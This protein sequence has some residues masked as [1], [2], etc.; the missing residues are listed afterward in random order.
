VEKRSITGSGVPHATI[1]MS[2]FVSAYRRAAGDLGARDARRLAHQQKQLLRQRPRLP[3]RLAR[4]LPLAHFDD[5]FEDGLLGLL[6]EPLQPAHAAFARRLFQLVERR[7]VELLDERRRLPRPQPR[8]RHQ[9][10]RAV[11]K[12]APQVFEI[13]QGPVLNQLG[14]LLVDGFPHAGKLAECSRPNTF[15]QPARRSR[16]RRQRLERIRRQVVSPHLEGVF[17]LELQ[18]L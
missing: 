14:D 18:Q 10:Q 4:R 6:A 3:Q 12:L 8:N 16:V 17:A 13:L 15:V 1:S 2:P 7:D 11:G 5:A 9:I